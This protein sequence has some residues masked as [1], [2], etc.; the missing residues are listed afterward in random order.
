VSH[1]LREALRRRFGAAPTRADRLTLALAALT[2]IAH[3]I[4]DPLRARAQSHLATLPE[5]TQ[6]RMLSAPPEARAEDA[7]TIADAIESLIADTTD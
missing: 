6:T 7:R 3:L 2:E 4:A 5:E 1:V